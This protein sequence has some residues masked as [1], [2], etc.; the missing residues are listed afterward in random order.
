MYNVL[1]S[2]VK[3]LKINNNINYYDDYE[4]NFEVED[5]LD[6]IDEKID[7]FLNKNKINLNNSNL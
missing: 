1:L 2:Q 5:R 7:E 6:D 3:G 4:Y